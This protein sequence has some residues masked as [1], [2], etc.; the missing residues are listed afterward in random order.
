MVWNKVLCLFRDSRD[1]CDPEPTEVDVRR[2]RFRMSLF[3]RTTHALFVLFLSFIS[4][5][6]IVQTDPIQANRSIQVVGTT[7]ATGEFHPAYSKVFHDIS[8]LRGTYYS[9]SFL[10]SVG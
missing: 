1:S 4:S 8:Q 5:A 9:R 3:L 7:Y 6:A 10:F 2:P